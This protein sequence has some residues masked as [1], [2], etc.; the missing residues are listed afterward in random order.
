MPYG[1]QC[2]S[3][4]LGKRVFRAGEIE[5]YPLHLKIGPKAL[6]HRGVTGSFDRVGPRRFG[7]QNAVLHA[8]AEQ[9]V[10]GIARLQ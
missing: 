1:V 10:V 2:I 9:R 6:A 8:H 7:D 5:Q 3:D 4:L